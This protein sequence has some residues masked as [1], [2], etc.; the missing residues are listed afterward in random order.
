MTEIRDCG[1]RGI[2][3]GIKVYAKSQNSLDSMFKSSKICLK[4]AGPSSFEPWTGTVIR[5][6][7]VWRYIAWLP[8][9]RANEN[10][11]RVAT[12]IASFGFGRRGINTQNLSRDLYGGDTHRPTLGDNFGSFF[13]ILQMEF[14]NFLDI[15]HCLFKIFPLCIATLKRRNIR[16]KMPGLVFFYDSRKFVDFKSFFDSY[17]IISVPTARRKTGHRGLVKLFGNL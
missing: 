4:S 2:E 9:W 14:N 16:E 7:S 13:S 11:S 1:Y 3:A 6:P 12:R 15:F 5:R 10:P 8:F 17:Y